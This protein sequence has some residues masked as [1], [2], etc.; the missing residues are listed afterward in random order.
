MANI[1]ITWNASSNYIPPV[2][3]E[4]GEVVMNEIMASPDLLVN[5]NGDIRR[6][7]PGQ[8]LGLSPEIPFTVEVDNG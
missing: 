1:V 2:T 6:I 3:N 7:K 8:C 5:I 4:E